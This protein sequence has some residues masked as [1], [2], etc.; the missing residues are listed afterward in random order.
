MGRK[1]RSVCM[2]ELA[3]KSPVP[4]RTQFYAESVAS[5]LRV[6]KIAAWISAAISLAFGIF[7]LTLG[8]HI[9]WIGLLN[10]VFAAGRELRPWRHEAW[11]QDVNDRLLALMTAN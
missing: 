5:R 8:G 7:Q 9:W 2:P 4:A 6:L 11:A 3:L 1:A 10:L